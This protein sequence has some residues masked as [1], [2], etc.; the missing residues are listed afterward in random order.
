MADKPVNP[1][2]Q[3]VH[4]YHETRVANHPWPYEPWR[5]AYQL[6]IVAT[7]RTQKAAKEAGRGLARQKRCDLVIHSRTTGRIVTKN[8]YGNDSPR[9]KG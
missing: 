7:A 9:R 2:D 1:R 5:V 8:S 3:D 4:V 6:M